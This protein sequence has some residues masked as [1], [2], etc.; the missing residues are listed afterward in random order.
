MSLDDHESA[1]APKRAEPTTMYTLLRG[2]AVSN[3]DERPSGGYLTFLFVA[4]NERG[5]Y[6]L[7]TL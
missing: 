2:Y 4:K 5:F 1:L 6:F 3:S 7:Y